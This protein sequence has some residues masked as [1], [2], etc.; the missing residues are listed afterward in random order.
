VEPA[1]VEVLDVEELPLLWLRLV[2]D[3]LQTGVSVIKLYFF[4]TDEEAKLAKVFVSSKPL[5]PGLIS[6]SKT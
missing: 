3:V 6:A 4:V 5:Q 2:E 1:F